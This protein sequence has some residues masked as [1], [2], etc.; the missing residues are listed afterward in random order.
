VPFGQGQLRLQPSGWPARLPS[1]GHIGWH[2]QRCCTQRPAVPQLS[3]QVQVSTHLP[4]MH[5]LPGLHVTPAHA[6][7]AHFPPLQ[8]CPAGQVMTAHGSPPAHAK[9]QALFAPQ[10]I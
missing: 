2:T 5:M 9:W 4:S 8:L 6:S 3:L 10:S 7:G 1:C